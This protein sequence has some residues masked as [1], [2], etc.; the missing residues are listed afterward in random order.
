MNFI[1]AFIGWFLWNLAEMEI[2]RRRYAGDNDPSTV[3]NFRTY[4]A[5]KKFTWVGSFAC[6]FLFLWIR[7]NQL[8]LDMLEPVMGH[9]LVWNDFLLLAP[10]AGFEMI[11]FLIWFIQRWIDKKKAQ[12]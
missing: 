9:K 11:I 10:G 6:I 5:E 4:S 3:F 1:G 12:G 7:A 8:N 2:R